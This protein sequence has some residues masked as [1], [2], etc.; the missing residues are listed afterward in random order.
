MIQFEVHSED[1]NGV[2]LVTQ[3]G[4]PLSVSKRYTLTL[5]EKSA[6]RNDLKTWRGRDFTSDELRGFELMNILGAWAMLSVTRDAG[7]NGKEYTNIGAV[8]PVPANMKK[9]GLPEPHN[10]LVMYSIDE[11]DDAAFETLSEGIKKIIMDSPE[12]QALSPTQSSSVPPQDDGED[13]P[14]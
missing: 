12:Y 7:S 2:A 10:P 13:I 8:M 5:S 11:H 4:E 3:K 6:L 14:F 9:A 1:E